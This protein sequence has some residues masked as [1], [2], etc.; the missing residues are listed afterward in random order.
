MLGYILLSPLNGRIINGDGVS[1]SDQIE[2]LLDTNHYFYPSV[3][4]L[5]KAVKVNEA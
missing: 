3:E 1:S 5:G 4:E 2:S